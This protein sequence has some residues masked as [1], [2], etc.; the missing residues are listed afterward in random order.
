MKK[1]KKTILTYISIFFA[2]IPFIVIP[3]LLTVNKNDKNEVFKPVSGFNINVSIND[4][5]ENQT[6]EMI[7]VLLANTFK[8]HLA[9]Q[10]QFIKSQTKENNIKELFLKAKELSEEYKKNQD[11]NNINKLFDFYSTNWLFLLNNISKFE[12]KA[13]D[14]WKLEPVNQH[15]KDFLKKTK[16][17]NLLNKTFNFNDN[18]FNKYLLGEESKHGTNNIYYLR[19]DKLIFRLLI[20]KKEPKVVIDKIILF[21]QSKHN[22]ISLEV[23]SNILHAVI[24]KDQ[25]HST[26]EREIIGEYNLALLGIF[27]LGDNYEKE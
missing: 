6:K 19:K 27:L 26:F 4:V 15:S 22:T 3:F 14:F 12:Y 2:I 13:L 1:N 21:N 8:N 17:E 10:E 7:D 20:S 16:K 24:H 23:I 9:Q 5:K 25:V 18:Y 11:Q